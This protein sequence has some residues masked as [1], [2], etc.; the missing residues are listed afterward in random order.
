WFLQQARD[1]YDMSTEPREE[2]K[3]RRESALSTYAHLDQKQRER[4]QAQKNVNSTIDIEPTD[5]RT[6]SLLNEAAKGDKLA[7][8]LLSAALLRLRIFKASDSKN[9]Q[10]YREGQ[11]LI[12]A[13][14]ECRF[15]FAESYVSAPY[16]DE[17][18]SLYEAARDEAASAA[19]NREARML[20]S[21]RY[22]KLVLDDQ[23]P[24]KQ[25]Y[26][27]YLTQVAKD[28]RSVDKDVS[29]NDKDKDTL[30]RGHIHAR[31]NL[32]KLQRKY[33]KIYSK[34]A[35]RNPDYLEKSE[36]YANDAHKSFS[37]AIDLFQNLGNQLPPDLL[38]LQADAYL[39]RGDMRSTIKEQKD[40]ALSDYEQA[41]TI[42][43][44]M[45][46]P[47]GDKLSNN[48]LVNLAMAYRN[49]GNLRKKS[50]DR[51]EALSDY[52]RAVQILLDIE[53]YGSA[54]Q[55][56]LDIGSIQ[57]NQHDYDGALSSFSDVI[58]IILEQWSKQ[59]DVADIV[60]VHHILAT[61][62]GN[63]ALACSRMG[64]NS[65]ARADCDQALALWDQIVIQPEARIP[66]DLPQLHDFV[67]KLRDGL[68]ACNPSDDANG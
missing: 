38:N 25:E 44:N 49:R 39:N 11:K 42:W 61:A 32:G 14:N 9:S 13:F 24:P 16:F 5:S 63:R 17:F 54:V 18:I 52:D 35:E 8:N 22:L 40:E 37:E 46:Q 20:Q 41:I 62:Y 45:R 6:L 47:S 4:D 43:E 65:Q 29:E 53:D 31:L 33:S 51:D 57:L 2:A 15:D 59:P 3:L 56:L 7:W 19:D 12:D 34:H 66:D 27:E 30:A 1:L 48:I 60:Q 21:M 68:E 50:G 10:D 55:I 28:F 23:A 67:K 64:N 26:L 58:K 36:N